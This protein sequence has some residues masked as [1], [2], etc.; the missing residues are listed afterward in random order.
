MSGLRGFLSAL[1]VMF[2]TVCVVASWFTIAAAVDF[3]EV[4]IVITA[5]GLSA[6]FSA[7]LLA[8]LTRGQA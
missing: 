8:E 3:G 4:T 6:L 1:D 2:W 5:I 7:R